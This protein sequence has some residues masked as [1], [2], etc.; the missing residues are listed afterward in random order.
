MPSSATAEEPLRPSQWSLSTM[1]DTVRLASDACILARLDYC[2]TVGSVR[3]SVPLG[4]V[5]GAEGRTFLSIP[6]REYAR[7][8]EGY[9]KSVTIHWAMWCVFFAR[10]LFFCEPSLPF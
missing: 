8:V 2:H 10:V 9:A 1:S 4:R 6:D 3:S 5:R 7:S